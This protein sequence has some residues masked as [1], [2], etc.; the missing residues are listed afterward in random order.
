MLATGVSLI[1]LVF[2]FLSLFSFLCLASC[3]EPPSTKEKPFATMTVGKFSD[4]QGVR[5][6]ASGLGERYEEKF[7]PCEVAPATKNVAAL[8]EL[9]AGHNRVA[10]QEL[11]LS[12]YDKETLI[13]TI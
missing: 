12:Y 13:C 4:L 2:C 6:T 1:P 7:W 11:N 9:A 10:V 8:L 5:S 3:P